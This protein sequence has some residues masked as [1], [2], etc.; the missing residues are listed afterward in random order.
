M[1]GA[2]IDERHEAKL[3][4]PGQPPHLGRVEERPHAVGERHGDPRRNP[5]ALRMGFKRYQFRQVCQRH[6]RLHGTGV[7]SA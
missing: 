7:R 1:H 6:R 5:H 2:W 4:D 3:A